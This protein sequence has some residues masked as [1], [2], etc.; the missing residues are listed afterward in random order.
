MGLCQRNKIFDTF[1][2]T[3]KEED[4]WPDRTHPMLFAESSCVCMPSSRP[5]ALF[6][7]SG[8]STIFGFYECRNG[9]GHIDCL[10]RSPGDTDS[11][12]IWLCGSSFNHSRVNQ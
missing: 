8:E 10:R 3:H 12:Y 11:K 6:F 7:F 2:L 1:S 4:V 9:C 5:V